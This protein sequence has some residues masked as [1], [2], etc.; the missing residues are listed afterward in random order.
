MQ[1]I[2][3]AVRM[4]VIYQLI[5]LQIVSLVAN[6]VANGKPIFKGV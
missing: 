1:Q 4:A 5:S 2:H 6:N 3:T